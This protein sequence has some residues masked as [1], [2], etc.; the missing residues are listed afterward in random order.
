M[1]RVLGIVLVSLAMAVPFAPASAAP[2]KIV[3]GVSNG[4]F[5]TDW[6]TQ[7]YEDL[8]KTFNFYKGKGL[9]TELIV[10]HAGADINQQIQQCRNMIN[11]GVSVLMVNANSATGLNGVINEAKAAGIPVVS[12][13]Q[14]VTNSY[15]INVTNEHT[16]WATS[17]AEWLAKELGG[18]GKVIMMDGLPGHPAAEAR[19]K[20][21]E[22]VF[23]KYPGIEILKEEYGWWDNAKAQA[24]MN[25]LLAAYPQIDGV[26]VEDSMATG[27]YNAFLAA[28]RPLPVMTGDPMH[29]FLK[30]W[31]KQIKAGN[32]FRVMAQANPPGV[33]ATA[34]GVAVYIA[35]GKKL[36]PLKDN[37]FF[38]P[39]TVKVT[40][41]NLAPTLQKMTGARDTQFLD[42]WLNDDQVKALFQ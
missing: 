32:D 41:E 15:A 6:R 5:G 4:Y 26:F 23:K 35:N 38:I 7:M 12:F 19:K 30:E 24:I 25:D 3:I 27:V 9:A 36:K 10:Q 22:A 1:R 31:D 13:D 42:E 20:A 21:A 29:G 39:I 16:G 33:S 18:K 28:K 2:K 34:L 14:A 11:Q 17:L 8:E 37:T 40:K